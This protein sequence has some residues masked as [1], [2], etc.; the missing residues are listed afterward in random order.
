MGVTDPLL[1][2][3]TIA[4]PSTDGVARH[5]RLRPHR[6][7]RSVLR[8]VGLALSAVLVSTV[9]IA[10]VTAMRFTRDIDVVSIGDGDHARPPTIGAYP[11]GFNILIVGSDTGEGQGDGFGDREAELNDVNLLL[12]VSADHSRAIAI[13]L[14]R[15]LRVPAPVCVDEKGVEHAALQSQPLNAALGRG[16]LGCVVD[17]VEQLT[18]LDIQFAGMITFLGVIELTNAVGGVPVCIDGPLVDPYTGINLPTA[19]EHVI[20]GATA[21]AFLRSRHGVGDG[22]DLARISSQR[23]YLASLVRTLKSSDT[24]GDPIRLY[25]IAEVALRNMTLSPSLA[26]VPTMM[27][28][29]QALKDIELDEVQF[30]MYPSAYTDGFT[31]LIPDQ[32]VADQL[33]AAIRADSPFAVATGETGPGAALEPGGTDAG[34]PDAGETPAPSEPTETPAP[35]E[36][37]APGASSPPSSPAPTSPP[38]IEGLTGQTAADRTC[39]VV[40][41]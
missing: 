28:I 9:A 23:V 1:S 14:P 17:T 40:N 3:R 24:L 38:V 21:L 29:A 25:Q 7:G 5:G 12:H 39:S 32:Q 10:G 8:A 16:G 34:G 18:G 15:D 37:A 41:R 11:G 31:R 2:G 20:S 22:S 13:S 27:S 19:G 6:D 4:V 33:M 30:V 26:N 36:T 35:T